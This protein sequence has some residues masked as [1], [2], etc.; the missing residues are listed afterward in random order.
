MSTR[1]FIENLNL[2]ASAIDGDLETL[3]KII[4]KGN[5]APLDANGEDGDKYMEYDNAGL[6]TYRE[7]SKV[8]GHWE[9]VFAGFEDYIRTDGSIQ[10]NDGWTPIFDQD[11]V[12]K[13]VV[14]TLA[15]RVTDIETKTDFISVSQNVDLDGMESDV[16]D[17]K[18]ITDL[19][20][21]TDPVDF[22]NVVLD[23]RQVIGSGALSGG[24]GL[25]V[26]VDIT[27]N[28]TD[29]YK[30]VPNGGTAGQ[31][32]EHTGTP[33]TAKWVDKTNPERGGIEYSNSTE[34]FEGD[35]VSQVYKVY[36]CIAGGTNFDPGTQ[37]AYWKDISGTQYSAGTF[38]PQTGTEYPDSTNETAGATWTISGLGAAIGYE[39]TMGSYSGTTVF[40]NDQYVFH[41]PDWTISFYPRVA[42]ERGGVY[43]SSGESYLGGDI[44]SYGADV[45]IAL[46]D[47]SGDVPDVSP[48]DWRLNSSDSIPTSVDVA[49][50]DPITKTGT[51]S[52]GDLNIGHSDVTG[53][54]HLPAGGL[55]GQVLKNTASGTGEWTVSEEVG[56]VAHN[57][58]LEY[59]LY[60]IVSY[61]GVAY[62]CMSVPTVNPGSFVPSDWEAIG[63][64]DGAVVWQ[65]VWLSQEYQL[66]DLVRDGEWTMIANKITSDRAAP[67]TVGSEEYDVK[68][69][70]FADIT[71]PSEII[72]TGHQYVFTKAG[73]IQGLYIKVPEWSIDSV[74]RV[75]VRNDSTGATAAVDNPLLNAGEWTS[76]SMS[77]SIV[78]IGTS[79]TVLLSFYNSPEADTITGNWLTDANAVITTVPASGE[80]II[81]DLVSPQF[82][83]YSYT[84]RDGGDRTAELDGLGIGSIIDI[85]EAGDSSRFV[86]CEVTAIDSTP[87]GFVTYSVTTITSSGDLRDNRASSNRISGPISQ[88]THYYEETG[89]RPNNSGSFS[90]TTSVLIIDGVDQLVSNSAFGV[91]IKFQEAVVSP[92]WDFVASSAAGVAGAGGDVT[93][94]IDVIYD[95]SM[96][97]TTG[98]ANL[99]DAMLDHGK[100]IE[101][102]VS[103][104]TG[105]YS[106]GSMGTSI[107]LPD[108][109]VLVTAGSGTIVDSYTTPDNSSFDGIN[110]VET[111]WTI[112]MSSAI[113]KVYIGIEYTG[114]GVG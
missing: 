29:G 102:R 46:R 20:T 105:L 12:T 88:A 55:P 43:F 95:S 94:A 42:V 49:V 74:S 98:T 40:D 5:D 57:A 8:N 56:G 78:G 61:V 63:G 72:H 52:G 65:G 106:G 38:T 3:R 14:D 16:A 50:T 44:V 113:G 27:H 30:H 33:G 68:D 47:T 70:A 11:V 103:K 59:S 54:K 4:S 114:V 67:Q 66:N 15:Q 107:T 64:T 53:S 96:D 89:Y 84:D 31:A 13:I 112:S 76:I 24:G 41:D 79:L 45:Y 35:I 22:E 25:D 37:P 51:L 73:W 6:N 83:S 99:Q 18:T 69:A 7:W 62:I 1:T 19:I 86:E 9:I 82:I 39:L 104:A 91:D 97:P 21:I 109:R 58:S 87:V 90:D 110:W 77:E 10:M 100:S 26:N 92:D 36:L 71:G 28:D 32:L 80:V 101:E 48:A 108:T 75:T 85:S 23:T 2:V 111:D 60:D 34:Y 93:E 17:S 81:S